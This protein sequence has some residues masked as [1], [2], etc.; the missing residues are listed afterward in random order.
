MFRAFRRSILLCAAA[1]V[2][3]AAASESGSLPDGGDL[4]L[5]SGLNALEKDPGALLD[6]ARAALAAG[7][8]LRAER[9]LALFRRHFPERSPGLLPFW[10]DLA[11]HR[12]EEAW[13]FLR[14]VA[15]NSRGEE[16]YEALYLLA[17]KAFDEKQY[18]V[19]SA[20]FG[21]LD[22][23]EVPA[24][25]RLYGRS[26]LICCLINSGAFGEAEQ[27]VT[28]SAAEFPGEA[29]LWEKFTVWLYGR[30]GRSGELHIYW[31]RVGKDHPAQPDALLFEGL[32]SGA[33]AAEKKGLFAQGERLRADAWKFASDD[34]ERRECL[35]SLA[36]LQKDHFPRHALKTVD[37]FLNFF[38]EDPARGDMLLVQ[39]EVLNKVGEY[40]RALKVLYEVLNDPALAP[41]LRARAAL[42][43]AFAAEKISDLSLAR[44]LYNSAIRRLDSGSPEAGQAKMQ[45]LEFFLRTGDFAP[46]AVLGE[47]LSG[48]PGVDQELLNLH[49][50]QALTRLKRYAAAAVEAAKLAGSKT[51]ARAAEGAWQLARLTELQEKT[52]EA[53]DLYL[54]FT[55][56]FPGDSRAPDAL[57]AAAGIA[58]RD[59]NFAS[60]AAEFVSFAE[61]YP[62]RTDLKNALWA[63]IYALLKQGA[64]AQEL[65]A[66]RL[67]E[68]LEKEFPGSREYEL[69]LMEIARYRFD[70]GTYDRALELLERFL[71]ARPESPAAPQALL[72]SLKIFDKTG[73]HAGTLACADRILDKFPS[74]DAAVDAAFFAGASCFRN[75]DYTRALKYYERAGELGGGGIISLVAAGEAADCHLQLR[76]PENLAAARKIYRGLADKTE[77]PAVRTQ[78]LFKLGLACEYG[79]MN[80]QALDA[81]EELLQ[82]AVSSPEVRRSAGTGDWCARAARNALRI[83]L[84]TL[85]MPD[86][87]QRAQRIYQLYS[88]LQVPGSMVELNRYLSEIQQHYNLL[89]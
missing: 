67:L 4:S 57:L 1:F 9:C 85:D 5:F 31:A 84:G 28:R 38:K 80:R 66:A 47:E 87:S 35:K 11:A 89:D 74:S 62:R 13:A 37:F 55:G 60:A 41:S 24:P 50:L 70:R 23:P 68:Q 18:F 29:R 30:S 65:Q 42:Q 16:R 58:L 73:N 6:T 39:G 83:I 14:S 8:V 3:G 61:R 48:L 43:G 17:R 56:N 75:G 22:R 82:L 34:G 63:A 21:Q 77:F 15:E 7:N 86:G 33:A 20:F 78:A 76:K 32:S 26:G 44:E 40:R 54:K 79:K 88:L 71:K 19:S 69:G 10:I 49:R 81:Y 46:A 72:L 64:P 53:R 25:W 51:P 52:K 36:M 45:L 27:L 2:C 12:S 59:R